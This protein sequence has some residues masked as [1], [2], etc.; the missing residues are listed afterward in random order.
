MSVPFLSDE[1]KRSALKSAREIRKK[2]S[3]IKKLLK[4]CKVKLLE[5]LEEKS[6]YFMVAKDM[7]VSDLI[8][9]LPGFGDIRVSRILNELKISPRKKLSGLGHRQ[10]S[11]L[12][13][14]FQEINSGT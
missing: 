6:M 14:Y 2:R 7:R 11:R 8:R 5:L 9:S 1:E 13:D 12:L 4:S 10:K 3:E